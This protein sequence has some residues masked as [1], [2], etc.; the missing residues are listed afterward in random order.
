ME[1]YHPFICLCSG[2]TLSDEA[3]AT[4]ISAVMETGPDGVVVP[5]LKGASGETMRFYRRSEDGK[6]RYIASLSR[7]LT[8]DEATAIARTFSES[9]PEGD[10]DIHWSQ[11]PKKDTKYEE[12]S[13]DLLKG[14][15]VEAAK[16]NHNHWLRK[17]TDEGWRFGVSHDDNQ[18]TSPMCRDWEQ[19]PQSYKRSELQRMMTLLEVVERMN[20]RLVRK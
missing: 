20:L 10:F 2:D 11:E 15:A 12:V 6:N 18:K 17:R 4:W 8:T 5:T 14:I 19:L 16:L 3:V 9:Y 7:N 13:D 1:K